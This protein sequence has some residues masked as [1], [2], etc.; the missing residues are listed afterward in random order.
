MKHIKGFVII[1]GFLGPRGYSEI[2]YGESITNLPRKFQNLVSNGLKP[3][4][5]KK[6]ALTAKG[7]LKGFSG[8]KRLD[9]GRIDMT[10]AET[11]Q[12]CRALKERKRLVVLKKEDLGTQLIGRYVEGKPSIYPLK[13]A[14]LS[15]NGFKTFLA[16]ESAL[17]AAR[18][19]N[20]QAQCGATLATFRLKRL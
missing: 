6:E 19:V 15:E 7:G 9:L 1:G 11:E 3:F 20:R 13:G 17:Y 8:L 14:L 5:T 16:F 4:G 12:E 10:V 2:L 18:E